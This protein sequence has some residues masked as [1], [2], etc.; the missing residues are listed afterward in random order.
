MTPARK[1]APAE[2]ARTPKPTTAKGGNER[3]TLPD[4]ATLRELG[5]RLTLSTGQLH[6][7]RLTLQHVHADLT[8]HQADKVHSERAETVRRLKLV[9]KDLARLVDTCTRHAA[10]LDSFPH[11]FLAA[12]GG[13]LT[14]AAMND[15]LGRNLTPRRANFIMQE[16]IAAGDISSIDEIETL[17][18]QH[19]ELTGVKHGAEILPAIIKRLHAP[20]KT[21]V[22]LDK[23]NKGGR[24]RNLAR[25]YLVMR[26]A[27]AAPEIIG[28]KAGR[29]QTG[30]FVRL[31]EAVLLPCGIEPTGVEK[32]VPRIVAPASTK[33]RG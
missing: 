23:L 20:L 30:P 7:L 4:E 8:A 5:R 6:C 13:M 17:T 15:A 10:Y 16:R 31:C 28:S 24:K 11:D 19:R 33:A 29:S 18:L 26:L 21:W 14:F 3:L 22:D 2:N 1:A 9:E 25:H 12:A 32:L 27:Q